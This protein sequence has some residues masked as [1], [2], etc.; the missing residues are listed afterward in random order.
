MFYAILQIN[1]WWV[2]HA[3][4]LFAS[5]AFP[6]RFRALK[7]SSKVTYVH[8][9]CVIAGLIIPIIPVIA[10]MIDDAIKRGRGEAVIGTLGYI[11]ANSPPLLSY[12]VD[13]DV[14]FFS[15][16]LPSIILVEIGVVILIL[17]I[18]YIHKV[19]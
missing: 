10:P 14:V 17:T 16:I 7:N 18:W 1:I 6:Y 2:L 12:G 19:N 13:G 15:S 11:P 4:S 8:I 9:G 5:V 3:V